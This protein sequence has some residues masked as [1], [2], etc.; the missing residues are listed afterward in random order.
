MKKIHYNNPKVAS[1]LLIGSIFFILGF[2]K[3]LTFFLL[4]AILILNGIRE[5]KKL[6]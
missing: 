5:N 4:G 1:Y 2:S 6:S 3:G